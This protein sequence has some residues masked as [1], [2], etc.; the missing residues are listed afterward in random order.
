MARNKNETY[1][2]ALRARFAGKASPDVSGASFA[3]PSDPTDHYFGAMPARDEAPAARLFNGASVRPLADRLSTQIDGHARAETTLLAHAL[4][5]GVGFFWF[6]IAGWF[7]SKGDIGDAP[8]LT[9]LFMLIAAVGIS[10]ALFG[11]IITVAAG[12]PSQRA[13]HRRGQALGAQI[14]LEA[15]SLSDNMGR[16]LNAVD[17]DA[18]LKSVAFADGSGNA[19]E[20]FRGYLRRNVPASRTPSSTYLFIVL[21]AVVAAAAALAG[22]NMDRLTLPLSAYPLAFAAITGGALLYA[23]AG[24]I[25]AAFGAGL[26]TRSEQKAENTALAATL[27]AFQAARAPSLSTLAARLHGGDGDL[28]NRSL[29]ETREYESTNAPIPDWRMRDSGPRFVETGFQSAPKSFRTDAF[30][31]KFRP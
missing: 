27:S 18:F 16:N 30:E 26:K 23:G 7:L 24:F 13:L 20:D 6:A 9:Q 22:L 31:K 25:A 28:S 10:A 21:L 11:A 3:P 2:G 1:Y 8:S 14:A 19:R 12:R 4:R 5:L 29:D 17:A 15:Q